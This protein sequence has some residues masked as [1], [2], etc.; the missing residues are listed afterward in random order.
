MKTKS[1]SKEGGAAIFLLILV[2][3][4]PAL[5]GSYALFSMNN[6]RTT[7]RAIHYM[8]AKIIA[9]NA[10]SIGAETFFQKLKKVPTIDHGSLQRGLNGNGMVRGMRRRALV[11]RKEA[12]GYKVDIIHFSNS[13]IGRTNLVD[14][15]VAVENSLSGTKVAL[16]ATYKVVELSFLDYAI[17]SDGI[18][19]LAPWPRMEVHGDVRVNDQ[20]RIG[21]KY[22]LYFYDTLWSAAQVDVVPAWNK[23]EAK[24][25]QKI[26]IVGSD[27]VERSFYYDG[28]VLDGSNPNW[29]TGSRSRWGEDVVKGNVPALKVPTSTSDNHVLIEPR[30]SVNDDSTLMREKLAWKAT[31]SRGVIITVDRTGAVRYEERGD[32]NLQAALPIIDIAE[33]LSKDTGNGIYELREYRVG[34]KKVSGW[35]DVDDS[36]MDGRETGA[37][38]RVV[39]IYMDKLLK[40]FPQRNIFYIEVEDE[41]GNLTPFLDAKS[42]DSSLKL[43]AVRIRN[44]NDISR[45]NNGLTIATHRMAYIE[46]NYNKQNKIPALIAADNVTALSNGWNDSFK[47]TKRPTC[48]L[49]T[50]YK[51]AFLIG[52]YS[53][54]DSGPSANIEG[55][56]NLVRYRENWGDPR[57]TYYY[58]GS[59]VK[60]FNSQETTGAAHND[61]FR[62]PDR[63]IIYNSDFVGHPPPGM[64]T[65]LASPEI[66]QWHEISWA[67]AQALAQ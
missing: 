57:K 30:D 34:G 21:A 60:L 38:V 3:V 19:E 8:E 62:A 52:G 1:K 56:Q 23:N 28:A 67:E 54:K 50:W 58:D 29:E 49:D 12:Q 32:G 53:Y 40:K 5:I 47:G 6:Q 31:S 25:A 39:N 33:P 43:P 65:A 46:G 59:Y 15:V 10:V 35:I 4:V 64:P 44:G 36:F 11:S 63:V 18:F 55:F 7:Q 22:G 45:A 16:L 9:E 48:A 61:Y 27:G 13:R 24:N 42:A 26:F 14:I 20:V 17:F 37:G 41:N 51:A 66:V 2:M